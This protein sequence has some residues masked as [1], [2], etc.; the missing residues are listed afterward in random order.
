MQYCRNTLLLLLSSLSSS[1]SLHT[2]FFSE[3]LNEVTY[4]TFQKRVTI[5]VQF[6]A[7]H[8]KLLSWKSFFPTVS[9]WNMKFKP[10][11][12]TQWR[13]VPQYLLNLNTRW[14]WLLSLT[15]MPLYPLGKDSQSYPWNETVWIPEKKTFAR[16]GII[17]SDLPTHILVNMLTTISKVPYTTHLVLKFAAEE[18]QSRWNRVTLRNTSQLYVLSNSVQDQLENTS[19]FLS[20]FFH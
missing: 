6:Y 3:L 11:L 7:L 5:Y 9:K 18:V 16:A 17:I 2:N 19:E 15:P 13:C 20:Y 14:R 4:V 1:S 10:S 12:Y 8:A